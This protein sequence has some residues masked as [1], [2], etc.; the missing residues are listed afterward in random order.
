MS[1]ESLIIDMTSWSRET[2]R[3]NLDQVLPVMIAEYCN[4]ASASRKVDLLQKMVTCLQPVME[5]DSREQEFF[6]PVMSQTRVLYSSICS[7]ILGTLQEAGAS[8]ELSQSLL[9]SL[10]LLVEVI[11]SLEACIQ[12]VIPSSGE[13]V[14]MDTME[15]LPCNILAIVQRSFSHCKD[16]HTVYG[17]HFPAV[18]EQL[19]VLFKRAYSLQKALMA[20]LEVMTDPTGSHAESLSN[21]CNGF[22]ELCS[23]IRGMDTTLLVSTWRFLVKLVSKHKDI[24]HRIF[25]VAPLVNSLCSEVE[26]HYRHALQLAPRPPLQEGSG[27][28]QG[29]DEKAFARTLKVCS[30]CFKMLHH[31]VKEST[32]ECLEECGPRVAQVLLNLQ[33]LAP[34]NLEAHP[35]S[36]SALQDL[37]R[38]VLVGIEPLTQLFIPSRRFCEALLAT[39]QDYPL[40]QGLARLLTLITTLKLLPS[41]TD[42]DA[43][44]MWLDPVVMPED[45]PRSGLVSGIFTALRQCYVEMN[46]PI[47]F[48]GIM[49]NGRPQT[50]VSFYEHVV[51]HLC[52]FVATVPAKLFPG[53]EKCLLQSVLSRDYS[54]VM[55]AMDVWCFIARF[56][57]ADLCS[58]HV[59]FLFDL[60]TSLPTNQSPAYVHLSLLLRRLIP[61]MA[62]DHQLELLSTFPPEQHLDFWSQLPLGSLPDSARDTVLETIVKNC[63]MAI[64]G[65]CESNAKRDSESAQ[66]LITSLFCVQRLLSHSDQNQPITEGLTQPLGAALANLCSVL[67]LDKLSPT[68]LGSV[69]DVSA[70]VLHHLK[71]VYIL[72]LLKAGSSAMKE[73]SP[74]TLRI[75]CIRFLRKMAKKMLP[76]CPEQ[77]AILE[78]IPVLFSRVL[79]DS[80]CV[81]RQQA[82]E[83]FASFAEETSHESVVPECIREDSVQRTV[84]DYLNQIP[85]H[86]DLLSQRSEVELLRGQK[87]RLE[88]AYERLKG[89]TLSDARPVIGL[90]Q[91]SS[92]PRDS[93][94]KKEEPKSKRYR[95]D[96]EDDL[97]EAVRNLKDALTRLK[98]VKESAGESP[99]WFKAELSS[100]RESMDKLINGS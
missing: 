67:S 61:L 78:L 83:A 37:Q 74:L 49:C 48:P 17:D 50:E 87:E 89:E 56:G 9:Q 64:S 68:V 39:N 38:S 4:G 70:H 62:S 81:I 13:T 84:V 97:R 72:E 33:S 15:S 71:P 35:I 76:S 51:V 96:S 41:G 88:A 90:G 52:G 75:A 34:P 82:L 47:T 1:Q 40:N 65:W 80:N 19:S 14:A 20:L 23:I 54:V 100:T 26:S 85:T 46:K 3:Q 99:P 8:Q 44:I 25:Q 21:V 59:R 73:D 43:R 45:E 69:V 28:S 60:M 77:S 29:G 31:M 16:S 93:C 91:T 66:Q 6:A 98:E 5:A 27:G 42:D 63:T 12:Q 92:H 58:H 32:E 79:S 18:S 36:E 10:K 24:M 22:H 57:S 86:A 11:N 7:T 94:D 55:V 2:C 53:I 30:L 95:S